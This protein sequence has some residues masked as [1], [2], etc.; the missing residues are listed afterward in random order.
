[1]RTES[2]SSPA[3]PASRAAPIKIAKDHWNKDRA[4]QR[5]HRE[6]GQQF[7]QGQA[8][9]RTVMLFWG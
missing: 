1:M 2:G 3:P 8:L 7:E 4:Q 6:D 9:H 5:H